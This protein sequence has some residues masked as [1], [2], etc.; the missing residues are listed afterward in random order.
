MSVTHAKKGLTMNQM[1][2]FK[3]ATV[4]GFVPV[5]AGNK[6]AG[7][8]FGDGV[9]GNTPGFGPGFQGSSPCPRASPL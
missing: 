7:K 2:R 4:N 8:F 3:L 6:L 5:S 1:V 9:I